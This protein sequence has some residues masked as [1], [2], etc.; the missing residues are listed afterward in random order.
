MT[1]REKK[2]R[3]KSNNFLAFVLF[4]FTFLLSI[5]NLYAASANKCVYVTSA[6]NNTLTIIDPKKSIC[7][8]INADYTDLLNA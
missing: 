2:M 6:G 5:N 8:Q 3:G 4:C 7:P 1:T